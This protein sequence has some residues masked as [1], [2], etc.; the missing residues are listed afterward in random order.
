LEAIAVADGTYDS[1]D[2]LNGARSAHERI[3]NS[4]AEGDLATLKLLLDADT[5][6]TFE[7]EVQRRRAA[8]ETPV[9]KFV[10]LQNAKIEDAHLEGK[11][12]RIE[13]SFIT[14]VISALKDKVGAVIAGDESRIANVKE[15]WTFT[16]DLSASG[17]NWKLAD[18]REHV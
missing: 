6:A 3:L 12:A 9:F 13:V 16:R 1:A 14:E 4:F 2:F 18:T 5:F 8:D 10:R 7:K 15:L 11:H 17:Q